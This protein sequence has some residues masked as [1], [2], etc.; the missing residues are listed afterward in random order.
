MGD[1]LEDW[2]DMVRSSSEYLGRRSHSVSLCK[3]GTE[4]A[5]LLRYQATDGH[6]P[7]VYAQLV[8]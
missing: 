8:R 5:G 6:G 4:V 2:N 3:L 1:R 7:L